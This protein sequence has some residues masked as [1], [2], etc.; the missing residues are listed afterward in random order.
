MP[1]APPPLSVPTNRERLTE[2]KKRSPH[3]AFDFLLSLDHPIERREVD[4]VDLLESKP[5][6]LLG[7][8]QLRGVGGARGPD[9]NPQAS[10]RLW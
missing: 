5:L 2:Y 4:H 3:P 8:Q 6:T 10:L 7:R 1:D 9:T